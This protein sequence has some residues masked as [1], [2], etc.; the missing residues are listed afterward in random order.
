M[1]LVKRSLAEEMDN[2][3]GSRASPAM[4]VEIHQSTAGCLKAFIEAPE[5]IE[6]LPSN[7]HAITLG[8]G[9]KPSAPARAGEG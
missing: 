4:K 6:R 7:G 8:K 3:R 2:L 5:P 9:E 1:E